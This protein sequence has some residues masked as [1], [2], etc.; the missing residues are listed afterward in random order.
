MFYVYKEKNWRAYKPERPS[1]KTMK[2]EHRGAR[3]LGQNLQ[4]R[5]MT[6]DPELREALTVAGVREPQ[7]RHC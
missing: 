5:T 2:P 1:Q 6:L 3:S 4:E 7:I